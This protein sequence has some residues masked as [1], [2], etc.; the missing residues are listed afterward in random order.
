ME[1]VL[2]KARAEGCSLLTAEMKQCRSRLFRLRSRR[3]KKL[4]ALAFHL[5]RHIRISVLLQLRHLR[6]K[7][8]PQNG[9]R[10]GSRVEARRS[11]SPYCA[12]NVA[13]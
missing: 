4:R 9:P 6:K 13:R 5:H 10:F 11:L 12:V 7:A 1:I 8:R 2:S 3:K